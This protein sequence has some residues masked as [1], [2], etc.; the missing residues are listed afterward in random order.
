MEIWKWHIIRHDDYLVFLEQAR[1][2]S[3]R[4]GKEEGT[5]EGYNRGKRDGLQEGRIMGEGII[6]NLLAKNA[7]LMDRQKR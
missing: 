4:D 7:R 5:Q 3:F 1:A 2:D 6:K